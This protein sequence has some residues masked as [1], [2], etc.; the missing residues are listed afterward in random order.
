MAV[1]SSLPSAAALSVRTLGTTGALTVISQSALLYASSR[2]YTL[3]I[4]PPAGA[5][6][7][8]SFTF[9][10]TEQNYDFVT[11]YNST[12][13]TAS[14]VLRSA[15]SGAQPGFSATGAADAVLVVVLS[16]DSSS[17][18]AGLTFSAVACFAQADG[19]CQGLATPSLT[20]SPS[21]P[22]SASPSARPSGLLGGGGGSGGAAASADPVGVGV[23]AALGALVLLGAA[24][25]G[26]AC[27]VHAQHA[28]RG[29]MTAAGD[30]A[31]T[32]TVISP[33]A[34][35]PPALAPPGLGFAAEFSG[36]PVFG[37]RPPAGP[38]PQ[39]GR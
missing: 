2:Y 4:A 36:A 27:C 13:L 3:A 26:V 37:A 30:G 34:R 24:V 12:Q 9:F 14:S 28:Q 31:A 6:V 17:N 20:P 33:L 16:T 1:S 8:L 23:G 19:S 10:D 32:V 15:M 7:Q 38:P 11:I 22:A 18:N 5:G 39:H 25:T 29:K 21:A 35:P